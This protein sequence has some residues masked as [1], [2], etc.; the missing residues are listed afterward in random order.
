MYMYVDHY[1]CACIQLNKQDVFTL[2]VQLFLHMR[3]IRN[4]Y[5][6]TENVDVEYN[7]I[8]KYRSNEGGKNR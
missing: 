4:S 2:L 7:Y 6:S 1:T 3:E 5:M 8:R